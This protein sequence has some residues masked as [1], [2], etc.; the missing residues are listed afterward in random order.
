MV[1]RILVLSANVLACDPGDGIVHAHVGVFT[2]KKLGEI[3]VKSF[4]PQNLRNCERGLDESAKID[5]DANRAGGA[6]LVER[7]LHYFRQ[8]PVQHLPIIRARDTDSDTAQVRGSEF[9][10]LRD[11]GMNERNVGDVARHRTW[12]IES[13]YARHDP[14][15]RI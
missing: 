1:T 2:G 8:L 9:R 4:R 3:D 10:P 5:I 7:R 11:G 12:N 14:F 13:E 15:D 6:Q